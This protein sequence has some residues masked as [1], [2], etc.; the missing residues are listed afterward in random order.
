MS[1]EPGLPGTNV[2]PT[3]FSNSAWAIA[4]SRLRKALR[5][6]G[7]NETAT[8]VVGFVDD[9]QPSGSGDVL[10]NEYNNYPTVGSM[11][12][13][14]AGFGAYSSAQVQTF[15]D[16]TEAALD[17]LET[18]RF[19]LGPSQTQIQNISTRTRTAPAQSLGIPS[20]VNAYVHNIEVEFGSYDNARAFFN[21]GGQFQFNS[22]FNPSA[23]TPTNV[24]NDWEQFLQAFAGFC[25]DYQGVK[26]SSTYAS[27]STTPEYIAN[28]QTIAGVSVGF[29]DLNASPQVIFKRDVLDTPGL[30]NPYRPT[31]PTNGGLVI[32]ANTITAAGS[33]RIRFSIEFI[34]RNVT[35]GEAYQNDTTDV[36][37]TGT[38]TSS[39]NAIYANSFNRNSPTQGALAV[40]VDGGTFLTT[41]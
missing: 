5:Q 39:V 18:Y 41:P 36:S 17:Q 29:Y 27:P 12:N 28:G 4:I 1:R 30:L 16:A 25:F 9:G 19:S 6:T 2:F 22:S 11:A 13:I 3:T 32:S 24:E 7:L 33:F 8:S 37:L 21:S 15:F 10:A 23:V 14:L 38:L 26:R 34:L 31:T 35:T 20:T 40:P